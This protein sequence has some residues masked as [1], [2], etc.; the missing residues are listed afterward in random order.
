MRRSRR[1]QRKGRAMQRIPTATSFARPHASARRYKLSEPPVPVARDTPANIPCFR[2]A[3]SEEEV[4]AVATV[5]RSGWLT[6]GPKTR[7]FEQAFAEYLGGGVEP[8]LHAAGGQNLDLGG[9]RGRAQRE[10]S[11]CQRTEK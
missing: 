11:R 9:A 2:P 10:T 3:I 5:L 1:L 6:T 7:E 4:E 8:R